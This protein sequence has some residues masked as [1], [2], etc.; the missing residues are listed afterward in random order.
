MTRQEKINLVEELLKL[1]EKNDI[2]NLTRAERAEFQE[3]VRNREQKAYERGFDDV[4]VG[5]YDV[6]DHEWE[7]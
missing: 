5:T 1:E 2:G 6:E 3:W 4:E 7:R